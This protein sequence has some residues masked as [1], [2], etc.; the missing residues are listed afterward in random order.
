MMKQLLYRLSFKKRIWVSFV[1]LM[2]VAIAASGWSSYAISSS[3][4]ER[5]ALRLSQDTINK[6]SQ[7]L[8][9]KLKKIV[10][11][12]MSLKMSDPYIE[13]LRD[14]SRGDAGYYY[15]RLSALQPIL[16]QLKF[17]D[18][19]IQSV[20]IATPIGDF[21]P[22]T[23]TRL[24]DSSFYQSDMYK[25]IKSKQRGVWMEGHEDSFFYGK[26][27][28]VSFVID[29]SGEKYVEDVFIVV[30]IKE[31]DLQ[32]LIV[33][34]VSSPTGYSLINKEGEP[35]I[36]NA[37]D[38]GVAQESWRM[39][40]AFLQHFDGEEK[41]GNFSY[42]IDGKDYLINF[43]RL[44]VGEG[45]IL[46]DTQSKQVV[47][48]EVDA[49]K[50][51]TLLFIVGFVL[52]ALLLSNM[53]T[54][55]LL[56]PLLRL[57]MLMKQVEHNDLDVRF[58]SVYQDEISQVGMRFN[59]ML[60]EIKKLIQTV[61]LGEEEKRKTE[62]KALSAQMEP[63]FLYNTLNTIYCKSVLGHTEAV[64]EMILSLSTMFQLGL[65]QGRDILLIEEELLH[66]RHYLT[67]QQNCYED[68]F[69]FHIDVEDE[70]ILQLRIPKLILQPLVENAILHG[71]Q[72]RE[73][74]CR[75][76]IELRRTKEVLYISVEDNGIGMDVNRVRQSIE[77]PLVPRKG[78]ALRNIGDRL[79]LFYGE[80]ASIHY[81]SEPGKGTKVQFIITLHEGE[82]SY[83]D[84]G[85]A[86]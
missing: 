4:V 63:H 62:I 5:N 81:Y 23:Y 77:G 46:Y 74:G 61:K 59:L 7:V 79:R 37:K 75:I 49:I 53:L 43:T 42:V 50:W 80:N 18:D 52:L 86:V 28:V 16:A 84:N 27:R 19:F 17:N 70:S 45:W 85:Y 58:H 25:K 34:Q 9:E 39:A 47:L 21:Y 65:S 1:L 20:L 30:N 3:I 48:K 2:T 83:A 55:L 68:R 56:R 38:S 26:D 10:L 13:V 72:D 32:N 82:R 71:F 41:S 11:S 35:V 44:N 51:L 29:G 67:L 54:G 78:Y 22:T 31:K 36:G 40:P 60:D 15:A 57:H 64:N 6:S 69:D 73:E 33:D 12:I 14:V 8:D 24:N 76:R 66:V